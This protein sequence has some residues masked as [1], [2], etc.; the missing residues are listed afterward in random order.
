[1][2]TALL[3]SKRETTGLGML[4]E[5]EADVLVKASMASQGM[6]MSYKEVGFLL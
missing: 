6:E 5:L 3:E 1:M 2:R 4:I